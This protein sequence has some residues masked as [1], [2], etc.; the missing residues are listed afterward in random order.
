MKSYVS[1]TLGD[2]EGETPLTL[3]DFPSVS[4]LEA[5]DWFTYATVT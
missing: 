5:E 2:K 4:D 3:R 1:K